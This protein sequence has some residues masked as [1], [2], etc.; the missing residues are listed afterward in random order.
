MKQP[1]VS[2]GLPVYNGQRYI[3]ETIDAILAQSWQDLELVISDNASTDRTEEIAR[4]YAAR[5]SR[6]RYFRNPVNL[7]AAQNY[8]LAFRRARGEFFKWSA[9]DDL[10]APEFVA[11]CVEVLDADPGA[12]L[13]WPRTV[14]IDADGKPISDKHY[15]LHVD[16]EDPV[17]RF[18]EMIGM[19][20]TCEAIFGLIRA[21]VLARTPLIAA[22][23]DSDRV[24]LAEL[25]L[26][27]RFRSLDE[28]M[29]FYRD[30][31]ER[32]TE[33]YPS[34][35]ERIAWFDPSLAGRIV[36]PHFRQLREYWRT[37]ARAGLPLRERWRCRV[38]LLGWSWSNRRRLLDD[39]KRALRKALRPAW[40]RLR[41]LAG[42]EQQA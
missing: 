15:R 41:R 20:H 33:V 24:L 6:V 31:D 19:A 18:A 16:A 26:R 4:A 39:L 7:G 29:F 27:G 23:A 22:Y 21:E 38:R 28:P 25:A 14:D 3:E 32:S 35:D 12:V 42:K 2:I 40:H 10:I 11:R 8:N 37:P 9:H 30:H 13:C 34:R 17:R 1:R 36:F 5:D